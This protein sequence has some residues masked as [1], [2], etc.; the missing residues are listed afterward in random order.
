MFFRANGKSADRKNAWQL[1]QAYENSAK[2]DALIPTITPH[3][4]WGCQG[5]H[6]E[7][8]YQWYSACIVQESDNGKD[9]E[10][11]SIQLKTMLKNCPHSKLF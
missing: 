11:S 7:T 5:I 9:V 6:E 4:H 3:G 1:D 2:H 10:S 8:I